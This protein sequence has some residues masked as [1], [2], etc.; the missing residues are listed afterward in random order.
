M[1]KSGV[2]ARQ[3]ER[4]TETEGER[5]GGENEGG[6]N[7]A[8]LCLY[9]DGGAGDASDPTYVQAPVARSATSHQPLV[10]RTLQKPGCQAPVLLVLAASKNLYQNLASAVDVRCGTEP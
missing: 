9:I 7:V 5:E 1:E 8:H 6:G 10:S 2:S 3:R 4:E